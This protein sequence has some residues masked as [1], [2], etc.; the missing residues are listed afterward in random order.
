MPLLSLAVVE[1]QL[2]MQFC[3]DRRT[4]LLLAR[5]C[6]FLR[7]C[8]SSDLAWRSLSPLCFRCTAPALGLLSPDLNRSL[9]RF[10]DVSLRW[11]AA[12][13]APSRRVVA[14]EIAELASCLRLRHLDTRTRL[15]HT[16]DLVSLLAHPHP[17]LRLV[18]LVANVLDADALAALAKHH[19]ASLR[20]LRVFR[21]S[22]ES[23]SPAVERAARVALSALPNLTEVGLEGLQTGDETDIA[24]IASCTS[25]RR[26]RLGSLQSSAWKPLLT[27]SP[28]IAASVQ[29]LWLTDCNIDPASDGWDKG[30]AAIDWPTCLAALPLLRLL[31]LEDVRGVDNVLDGVAHAGS[32]LPLLQEV[33]IR[34]SIRNRER[35]RHVPSLQRLERLL[36]PQASV[37]GAPSIA[38]VTLR[39]GLPGLLD[40]PAAL[41]LGQGSVSSSAHVGNDLTVEWTALAR[42]FPCRVRLEDFRPV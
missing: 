1:V 2:V 18:S 40:F 4:L 34:C 17:G 31:R 33:H 35:L 13:E 29:E 32:S 24:M 15:L 7:R 25:L 12:A 10:A 39:L 5:C 11:L 14:S 21:W 42:A 8:A 19:A 26:L 23:T 36:A 41:V 27:L 6:R 9:L 38:L 3:A 22:V 20:S 16:E 28:N 37:A 30:V